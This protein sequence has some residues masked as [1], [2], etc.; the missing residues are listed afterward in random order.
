MGLRRGRGRGRE[1]L[2]WREKICPGPQG[3]IAI[4]DKRDDEAICRPALIIL[5]H[6]KSN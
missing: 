2:A 3:Q 1:Y 6:F 4:L 5:K